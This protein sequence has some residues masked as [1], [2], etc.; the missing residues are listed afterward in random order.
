MNRNRH[1]YRNGVRISTLVMLVVTTA[2]LIV[3]GLSVVHQQ[4]F[5]HSLGDEQRQ[6]EREIRLL[7]QEISALDLRIESLLTRDKVQPR[8]ANAQTLLQP[9]RKERRIFLPPVPAA[10]PATPASR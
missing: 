3:L 1:R 2:L 5:A 9:I 7:K 8:L 10:T 4:N 6:T